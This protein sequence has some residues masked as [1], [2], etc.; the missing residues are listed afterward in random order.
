MALATALG[1]PVKTGAATARRDLRCTAAGWGGVHYQ[2]AQSAEIPFHLH[3][4]KTD[5]LHDQD[6]QSSPPADPSSG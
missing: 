1:Q 2:R 5:V 6:R 3:G 4:L